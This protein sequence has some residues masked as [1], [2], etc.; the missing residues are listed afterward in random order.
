[1]TIRAFQCFS[2]GNHTDSKGRKG[3]YSHSDLVNMA[4][5]FDPKRYRAPLVLG[6]PDDDRRAASYGE[7][8]GL[9]ALE[10]KL[11]AI[12]DVNDT[13]L[14]LVRRGSYK[15]VS[16]SFFPPNHPD[17]PR[18]GS[19]YLRHIGF[20]G[21]VPPAVK[22]MEPLA[23]AMPRGFAHA[24]PLTVSFSERCRSTAQR[25]TDNIRTI[26]SDLHAASPGTT[27]V[28]AAMHAERFL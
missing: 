25:R 14:G 3:V 20:L 24:S 17:N 1:M 23:F 5:G 21:S 11:F 28:R 26:A 12:A 16:S 13:L 27:L 10:G 18:P 9:L 19:Y 4:A 8:Q 6:H 22:G 7:T 15:N 2:A